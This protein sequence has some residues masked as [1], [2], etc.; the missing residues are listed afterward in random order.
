VRAAAIEAVL[1]GADPVPP[2]VVMIP[3]D[4]DRLPPG[5][6]LQQA[7]SARSVLW[8]PLAS[9]TSDVETAKYAL[10]LFAETDV[11]AAVAT[12]RRLATRLLLAGDT[13]T[14]SGPDTALEL[15]LP[16]VLQ[17]S[18]RTRVQLLPEEQ[19]VTGNYFEVAMSPTDISGRLDP[20]LAMTGVFRFDT[21]LTARHSEQTPEM[22]ACFD[23]ALEIVAEMRAACPL[24]LEIHDSR[25]VG[26]LDKWADDIDRLTGPLYHNAL[27][28]IA[29][30]TAALPL[31]HMNWDVNCAFNEF[32]AGV[33]IGVGDSLTGIH[34]DFVS[35]RS[36]I[37][38][39]RA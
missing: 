26:G 34:F 23:E 16:S 6:A 38:D 12:N 39:A 13:V 11:E 1:F 15:C 25:I 33:H 28:E 29:F 21:V 4:F 37:D 31:D 3:V 32:A 7:L 22:A 10:D 18:S 35:T 19:S 2:R 30:G 8:I 17:L 5:S 24:Q 36:W 9:F 14:L 20:H 27:T